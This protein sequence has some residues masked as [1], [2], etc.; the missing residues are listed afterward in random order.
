MLT[1][2]QV[3]LS[4]EGRYDVYL[5]NLSGGV[6][7]PSARLTVLDPAAPPSPTPP[8]SGSPPVPDGVPPSPLPRITRQPAAVS[9]PPGKAATL[10]VIAVGENPRLDLIPSGLNAAV[11]ANDDWSSP[12]WSSD[13]SAVTAA[14]GAFALDAGSKDAAVLATLAAG[15]PRNHSVRVTSSDT[16]AAGLVLAEI[17]DLDP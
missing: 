13:L 4:A 7:S 11:A 5:S 17:Y 2:A 8:A 15:A 12:G 3:D 1:L 16:A 6:L 10:S 14:T 9:V